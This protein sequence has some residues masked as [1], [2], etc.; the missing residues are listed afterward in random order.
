MHSLPQPQWQTDYICERRD[1][2]MPS[3]QVLR[4]NPGTLKSVNSLLALHDF[5]FQVTQG[6]QNLAKRSGR[7]N[8]H[9]S[10]TAARQLCWP[11]EGYHASN[12]KGVL[13]DDLS[14]PQWTA[15][16]LSNIYAISD[17]TL[18]KQAL[19]QVIHAMRD[20]VSLP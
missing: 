9:D 1:A 10:V 13:Y 3:L 2:V 18:S 17:P 6:N 15:G 4:R 19:L 5:P 16:Q 12:G 7:Y 20:A 11:N 8:A 14:L